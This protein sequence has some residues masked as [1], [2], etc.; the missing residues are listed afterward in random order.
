M[1]G[2]EP[3]PHE[4]RAEFDAITMGWGSDSKEDLAAR[5]QLATDWMQSIGGKPMLTDA[6]RKVLAAMWGRRVDQ[7]LK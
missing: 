5:I 2:D 4:R 3:K 6:E 7:V 1:A